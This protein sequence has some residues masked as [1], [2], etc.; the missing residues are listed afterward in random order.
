MKTQK[1][2][3]MA[4]LTVV[5][6]ALG[7]APA[8]ASTANVSGSTTMSGWVFYPTIRT[9]SA[10]GRVKFDP[11]NLFRIN[12]NPAL[13]TLGVRMADDNSQTYLSLAKYWDATLLDNKTL[14][15]GNASGIPFR[16]AATGYDPAE[17]DRTWGG[18]LD[19]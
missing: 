6:G 9:T 17:D 18:L 12:S 8:N 19:Y 15:S 7:V 2:I 4:L 16:L 1:I 14:L 5:F 10:L 13:Y 11:N 3:D